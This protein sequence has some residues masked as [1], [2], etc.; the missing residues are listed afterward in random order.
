MSD[1]F[2]KSNADFALRRKKSMTPAERL[3]YGDLPGELEEALAK[4]S[5]VLQRYMGPVEDGMLITKIT[6]HPH[7]Y[8]T[9]LRA[10]EI[11][12]DNLIVAGGILIAPIGG[13]RK[14]PLGA[15]NEPA[16]TSPPVGGM[17]A[18]G[19]DSPETHY[20]GIPGGGRWRK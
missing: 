12:G 10:Y 8:A 13:V 14:D 15:A 17:P 4:V 18:G 19:Y 7:T 1:P 11:E 5:T 2:E 6:V 16:T 20:Y 9:L 3:Q